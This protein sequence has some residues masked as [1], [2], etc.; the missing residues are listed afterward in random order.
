MPNAAEQEAGRQA[1]A[2]V[3]NRVDYIVTHTAPHVIIKMMRYTP[4]PHEVPLNVHFNKVWRDT[5]FDLWFFGHF[6]EQRKTP[7]AGRAVPLYQNVVAIAE[8]DA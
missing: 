4:D 6:H 8:K 1:L 7:L 3:G 5:Q 2:Q